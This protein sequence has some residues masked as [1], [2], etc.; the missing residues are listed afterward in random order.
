MHTLY[1]SKEGITMGKKFYF[2]ESMQYVFI[3]F[4]FYSIN[5]K[6]DMEM[7]IWDLKM[8]CVAKCASLLMKNKLCLFLPLGTDGSFPFWILCRRGILTLILAAWAG[9]KLPNI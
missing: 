2:S 5:M 1:T 7:E 6:K 8:C 9:N 4:Y 3:Y